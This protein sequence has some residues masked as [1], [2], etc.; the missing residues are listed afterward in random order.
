MQASLV[1]LRNSKEL[2]EIN[3]LAF[4]EHNT[5]RTLNSILEVEEDSER[6]NEGKQ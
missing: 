5:H 6:N 1:I 4:D 3:N 2:T